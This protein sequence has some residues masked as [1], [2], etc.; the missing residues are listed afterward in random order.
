MQ[1]LLNGEL[2]DSA[3]PNILLLLRERGIDTDQRGIAVAVNAEVV[4]RAAWEECALAEGD[5][6]E[7]ITAMQGG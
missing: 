7:V 4:T 2:V 3:A 6:V 5:E 1:L